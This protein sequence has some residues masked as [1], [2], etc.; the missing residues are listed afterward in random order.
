MKASV[1]RSPLIAGVLS[2]T[3]GSASNAQAAV[4]PSTARSQATFEGATIDLQSGWGEARACD[5]RSTGIWCFRSEVEMDR[6][7]ILAAMS[8]SLN[9][10]R[11]G[12]AGGPSIGTGS[13]GVCSTPTKLYD[14]SSFTGAV[15]QI[16]QTGQPTPLSTLG[17]SGRTSSYR[18]GACFAT[19]RRG[20]SVYPGA[21]S[22]GSSAATMIAGWD[23]ALTE[24]A[25]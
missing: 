4:T 2:V 12:L 10:S 13:T 23:N 18:I 5:V 9:A 25:Q 15:V 8:S 22:A 20:V 11:S 19:L 24:V 1:T 21:T 17:F 14:G 7:S 3:V 16:S 6:A